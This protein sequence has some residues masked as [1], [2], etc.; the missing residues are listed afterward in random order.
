MFIGPRFYLFSFNHSNL[1]DVVFA[2]Y[3][4]EAHLSAMTS[5]KLTIKCIIFFC[6]SMKK[7]CGDSLSAVKLSYK[8]F[9]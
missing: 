7:N 3:W 8:P 9:L 2:I 6:F 4:S 1:I 5:N